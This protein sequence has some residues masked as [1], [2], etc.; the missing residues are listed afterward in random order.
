MAPKV[1][2]R[3][4]IEKVKRFQYS[5]SK[6]KSALKAVED[7]MQVATASKLCNVPSTTLRNKLTF[8][9][10]VASTGHCGPYSVLGKN[11]EVM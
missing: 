1:N 5:P 10:L 9:S 3:G 6:V 7:G 2:P 8:K 11:L 4:K